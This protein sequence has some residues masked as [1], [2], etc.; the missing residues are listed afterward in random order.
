MSPPLRADTPNHPHRDTPTGAR[1]DVSTHQIFNSLEPTQVRVSDRLRADLSTPQA[2]RFPV[3][4]L[5][6]VH[7]PNA[8]NH[9]HPYSSTRP[10]LFT[11]SDPHVPHA[12]FRRGHPKV[13]S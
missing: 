11:S 5:K 1:E 8:P 4:E 7:N 12:P 10:H 13:Y 2:V 9:P 6:S 3:I